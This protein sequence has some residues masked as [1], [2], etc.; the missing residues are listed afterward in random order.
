MKLNRL[1]NNARPWGSGLERQREALAASGVDVGYVVVEG[2]RLRYAQSR[3]ESAPL[4]FCNGIGANLE[5]ALPLFKALPHIRMVTFDIPGCGGS[6]AAWF[7]PRFSA[8]AR[9]AVG[10]LDHLGYKDGFDV[11]GVSWG[12][13]LAQ[14]IA[15]E[16][17]ER[18]G[19]LILMATAAGFPMIPGRL[20]ASLRMFTPMRYLSRTYMAQNASIIYGGELRNRPDRAIDYARYTRAPTT[21]A[22]L[23]QLAAI[24]HFSSW[25]WLHRIHCPT[26]VLTGDDDPLVRPINAR[27]LAALLP[28]GRLEVVKGGGHLFMVFSAEDTAQRIESFLRGSAERGRRTPEA[29][30]LS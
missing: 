22:Y 26:L 12:G 30:R 16:Y 25:P 24:S 29:F 17:A 18:V 1:L 9:F 7:W 13:C 8:F 21:R 4:L 5:L 19:R 3:G 2:V 28:N 14:T 15:R 6:E 23:Q 10:L 20:R 11:A 27:L